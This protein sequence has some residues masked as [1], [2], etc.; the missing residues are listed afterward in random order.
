MRT[1]IVNDLAAKIEDTM[2][3][4]GRAVIAIEPGEN[5]LRVTLDTPMEQV[6]IVVLD[7]VDVREANR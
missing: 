6:D 3:L 4:A 7:V 5:H 1:Q 2:T